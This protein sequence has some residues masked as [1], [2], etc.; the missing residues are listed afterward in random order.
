MII[1]RPTF[2]DEIKRKTRDRWEQLEHDP[3]L[4]APWRQLF[5]QLRSNSRHVISEL[6]QNADDAGATWA[7]IRLEEGIFRF[8]HDGRDFD[9][10]DFESLCRFA[11]SKKRHLHTIGYRGIGFKTTFSLGDRVELYTPTLTVAFHAKRFTEP[12]WIDGM[13]QHPH[14]EIRV[15]VDAAEK[16]ESLHHYLDMWRTSPI[17]L[18]FFRNIRRLELNGAAIE[19]TILGPGPAEN[20]SRVELQTG[21]KSY[22]ILYI[23]SEEEPFPEEA[24]EEIR[25]E[26]EVDNLDIPPARVEIICGQSGIVSET[27]ELFVV[28]PT[29][30][31]VKTP[32]SCNAPFIQDPA[33][34]GLKAPSVSPTNR[35]LLRRIGRLAANAFQAWLNNG[36]LKL[37]E[38]SQAYEFLLPV[39]PEVSSNEL[40]DECTRLIIDAFA[41]ATAEANVVLSTDGT[42][43]PAN[44]CLN[45]PSELLKVWSPAQNLELFGQGES[46]ILAAEVTTEA[47]ERLERWQ[48]LE[49]LG[50]VQVLDVLSSRVRP[51][52]PET[53]E[54][55][56]RLWAF[57]ESLLKE[58][59]YYHSSQKLA[60]FPVQGE[61]RLYPLSKLIVLGGGSDAI[62]QGDWEFLANYVHIVDTDWLNRLDEIAKNAENQ[63]AAAP[64]A[65]AAVA[66]FQRMRLDQ[67]RG[68]A[69]AIEEATRNIFN[70]QDPGEAGI[71]LAYL[72][73]RA[74]IRAPQSLRFLC[75]DGN[76]RSASSNLLYD[77]DFALDS[78]PQEWLAERLVSEQY[79][80]THDVR[81]RRA[82]QRW[83]GSQ[84][85]QLLRF[86]EPHEIKEFLYSR[87]VLEKKILERGGRKPW[88]WDYKLKRK[89]YLWQDYDF[90]PELVSYWEEQARI[91]PTVWSRVVLGI[92]KA[93]N[94]N[95]KRYVRATAS[96][97]GNTCLYSLSV[98]PLASAWLYRLQQTEC[99]PD[100]AG[101]LHSPAT[102]YR[103]TSDTDYLRE[104]EPFLDPK[105]DQPQYAEF[106]ELLG[107]QSKPGD[108]SKLIERIRALAQSDNPPQIALADLYRALDRSIGFLDSAR[109]KELRGLF[110][111]EALI[112]ANDGSW[113]T[114]KGVFQYNSD[115]LPDL[116]TVLSDWATLKLWDWLGVPREPTTELL[117]DWLKTLPN[118]RRLSNAEKNRVSKILA[119]APERIWRDTEY[120][121]SIDGIWTKTEDFRWSLERQ[122]TNNLFAQFLRQTADFSMLSN[123]AR[124][125]YPFNTLPHL[126]GVIEYRTVQVQREG[127]PNQPPWVLSLAEHL[128]RI[129]RD[130]PSTDGSDTQAT[131]DDW[132]M[133]AQRLRS[134]QFQK[135]RQFMMAPYVDGQLAGPVQERVV[136]WIDHLLFLSKKG[137]SAYDELARVLS[138]PFPDPKIQQAIKACIERSSDWI[139]EYFEANFD[140]MPS[141]PLLHDGLVS[142]EVDD[143]APIRDVD[144]PR[145]SSLDIPPS[146]VDDL[147]N[148]DEPDAPPRHSYGSGGGLRRRHGDRNQKIQGF[149]RQ[150]GF[151]Y[152]E[153]SG[154]WSSVRGTVRKSY[155]ESLF[156]WILTKTDQTEHRYWIGDRSLLEGV[157]IPAEIWHVI[158][159]TPETTSIVLPTDSGESSLMEFTGTELM[160][161]IETGHLE[162]YPAAYRLRRSESHPV[163]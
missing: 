47:R 100:T 83:A 45:L 99:F 123:E 124:N 62:S 126:E 134:T 125:Q 40:G 135:V 22:E 149:W 110:G 59:Y 57:V 9:R 114:T 148:L 82:W 153:E 94:Y 147:G 131:V 109:Q 92:A 108:V 19:K 127:E 81:D 5:K 35:W 157:E 71:R 111:E 46:A 26:R 44:T 17:P 55:L 24:V 68:I 112:F 113:Y 42:V 64:S 119:R 137:P 63:L 27:G 93:W 3:A 117:V 156:H 138:D 7:R 21:T 161:E 116:P 50:S 36:E 28:L 150:Q 77:V 67:R 91:D 18:L 37:D 133:H 73:A 74:D 43:Q 11:Y 121:L 38:R 41:K 96:E 16:I 2:F 130:K 143:V 10:N 25:S 49:R 88:P 65:S 39:S 78:L 23:W 8:E 60:I 34:T 155:G 70:S 80:Q 48:W 104:I 122:P 162:L 142:R 12:V 105:F 13:T 163:K 85:S 31:A 151:V 1:P 160:R 139:A 4:V 51:P 72:A 102:I 69:V 159:K 30:V 14:T 20:S 66:L 86:P 54:G 61:D 136:G 97:R 33:R 152:S 101:K 144:A 79:A 141:V 154:T 103:V 145:F 15:V 6:L 146:D 76:W 132:M 140:L 129:R 58:F 95:W 120:W 106:L 53:T 115:D 56:L 52:R 84:K 107:V 128:L 90:E 158:Q 75:K 29:H 87:R 32:F 98:N 89:N 118:G